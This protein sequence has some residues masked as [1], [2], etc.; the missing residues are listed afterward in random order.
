MHR[1]TGE[2]WNPYSLFILVLST[3]LGVLKTTNEVW[4]PYRLVR[5]VTKSLFCMKKKTDEGWNPYRLV[6]LVQVTL[7]CRHK[8]QVMSGTHGDFLFR[9]ISR[10]F[11]SKNHT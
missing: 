1:I 6:I 2:G 9:S 3:L 11:A 4:E 8:R 5:L 7:F 10:C